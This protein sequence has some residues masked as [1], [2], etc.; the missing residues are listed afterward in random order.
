MSVDAAIVAAQNR[1]AASFAQLKADVDALKASQNPDTAA[2]NA[3]IAANINE[4]AAAVEALDAT[5]KPPV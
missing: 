4:S 2:D 5:I 1:F 3:A